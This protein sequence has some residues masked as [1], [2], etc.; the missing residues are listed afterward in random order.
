MPLGEPMSRFAVTGNGVFIVS[1]VVFL[2]SLI[3]VAATAS[4]QEK[5]VLEIT[6]PTEGTIVNP[7]QT[8]SVRITS[9]TPA[10]FPRV[11]VIGAKIGFLGTISSLPGEL[12]AQIP[13]DIKL[14]RHELSV[15]GTPQSGKERIEASIQID[16]ERPDLPASMSAQF[17]GLLLDSVGEQVYL[18]VSAQFFDRT[19]SPVTTV[20]YD[21][22][23]SSHL[24]FS[25]ANTEV[26]TVDSSGQVTA[27]APGIGEI[28]VKYTLGDIRIS[29]GIPV[30][31]PDP[32][33]GFGTNK[34][35]LSG[36]S[37]GQRIEPGGS[38]SFKLT[39]SSFSNFPGEIEFSAH[40]LPDG[41][42]ARFTPVAAH[43]PGSVSF[44]ANGNIDFFG[45]EFLT[46]VGGAG[47]PA[48]TERLPVRFE[49]LAA[50]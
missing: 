47:G 10:L 19:A 44:K 18:D 25:S 40:G 37:V 49:W 45:E 8:L 11:A 12:S 31:V 16:V 3:P 6:E 29:I 35:V 43:A 24:S 22:T 9:P 20:T 34:F 5:P 41:A 38:A 50:A 39:V 1:F 17:P 23:E 2:I 42:T 21:V 48:W 27:V 15:V 46:R 30:Q 7:G 26:V 28:T 4:P 13:N 33:G 36:P 14:G 32:N